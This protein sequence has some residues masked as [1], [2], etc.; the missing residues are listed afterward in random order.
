MTARSLF[1]S[2]IGLAAISG[3]PP[4]SIPG[5]RKD[6]PGAGE[7]GKQGD[8][9]E[10][11]IM[12]GERDAG[13]DE[14]EIKQDAQGGSGRWVAGPVR[15]ELTMGFPTPVFKTGAFNRSATDP[16]AAGMIAQP[17]RCRRAMIIAFE[18]S[19]GLG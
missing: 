18:T 10:E 16:L 14:E 7:R 5:R 4:G 13:P 19:G 8:F 1:A 11:G 9:K 2:I 12:P 3:Q 15:F 6:Q 17:L